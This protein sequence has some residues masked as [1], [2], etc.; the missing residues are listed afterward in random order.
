MTLTIASPKSLL[1]QPLP[2]S[3]H[4]HYPF[5]LIDQI[6]RQETSPLV[7]LWILRSLIEF[8]FPTSP[9]VVE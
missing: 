4:P 8:K 5:I 2:I 6:L 3:N 7:T 9:R 1:S